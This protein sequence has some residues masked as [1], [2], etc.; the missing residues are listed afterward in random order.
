MI[1]KGLRI[2]DRT[3][4]EIVAVDLPDILTEIDHGETFHWSI[5]YLQAQGHLGGGES[6]PIFEKKIIDSRDGFIISWNEL[7]DLS[8][9]F[10]QIMDILLIG[11]KDQANLHRYEKDQDMY[12]MCDITIEMVDS[13]YW[14]VFSLDEQLTKKLMKK[15]RDIKPLYSDF[16][17]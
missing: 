13:G 2:L 4:N 6:M 14:E 12:E 16:E 11:C 15:F 10:W 8:K 17:K 1:T 3:E 5:L 9:K 7:N